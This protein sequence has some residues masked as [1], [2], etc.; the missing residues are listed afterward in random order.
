[1]W[2]GWLIRTTS[3]AM[4]SSGVGDDCDFERLTGRDAEILNTVRSHPGLRRR[5]GRIGP[6]GN[7]TD[8]VSLEA[9]KGRR[10][11]ERARLQ[12][13]SAD[14][15]SLLSNSGLLRKWRVTANSLRL[16]AKFADV[17]NRQPII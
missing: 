9:N 1:M 14:H 11:V 16:V 5:R 17:E 2:L 10:G 4:A 12:A 6:E 3:G 7:R 8:R 13:A 15:D